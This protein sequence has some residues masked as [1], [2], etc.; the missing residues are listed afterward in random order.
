VE[1]SPVRS[2]AAGAVMVGAVCTSAMVVLKSGYGVTRYSQR[3]VCTLGLRT[4]VV[5][6][7]W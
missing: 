4:V 1:G 6:G 2:T 7:L 3:R 5:S